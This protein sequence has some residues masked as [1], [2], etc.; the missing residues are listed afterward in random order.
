MTHFARQFTQRATAVLLFLIVLALSAG[1]GENPRERP[2]GSR[3]GDTAGHIV[4][5]DQMGMKVDLA[6][7]ARRVVSLAP[8]VTEMMYALDAGGLLVGRTTY[9]DYPPAAARIES[10]G[11]MLTLDYERI[12][13]ARPELLLMTYAGNQL[14]NYEK[15]RGLGLQPFVL[16][17]STIADVLDD[18]GI[19]GR[20]I[21]REER[22]RR[23]AG[24]LRRTLDSIRAR[25]AGRP[26]VAAFIVID[27]SPLMTV[28]RGFIDEMLTVAGG[29]NIAAGGLTAYPKYSREELLRQDPEVIILP[30]YAPGMLEAL[31]TSYP[32][33]KSLRAVRNKRVYEIPANIVMRPGP[34]IGQGLAAL[35]EALHGAPARQAK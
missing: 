12:V 16:H 20:L 30:T 23:V 11:D 26:A 32:E 13:A 17:D 24:D 10:M 18:I 22:A 28:S 1:C 29:R 5:I 4:L 9:C 25:A 19:V 15:L 21:G 6:Q 2:E 3:N 27:R 8:N 35:Y 7:P 14:S 33:W 31:L 34:R